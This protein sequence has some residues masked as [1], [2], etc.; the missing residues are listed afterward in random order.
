MPRLGD[1]GWCCGVEMIPSSPSRSNPFP[2]W[3]RTQNCYSPGQPR[4]A[5]DSPEQPRIARDNPERWRNPPAPRRKLPTLPANCQ[6]Q[7]LARSARALR[8]CACSGLICVALR[9]PVSLARVCVV[10][11]TTACM[12]SPGL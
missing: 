10:M 6:H 8:F 3:T 9:C 4:K 11:R 1:S 5:Q 2:P 12:C 7:G